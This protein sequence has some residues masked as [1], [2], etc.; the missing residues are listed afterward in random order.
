MNELIY[1]YLWLTI[2]AV[3]SLL[4]IGYFVLKHFRKKT[5]R[6]VQAK[7]ITKRTL[8][9]RAVKSLLILVYT[10][11]LLY[12]AAITL[13]VALSREFDQPEI[14]DYFLHWFNKV[15][16]RYERWA[17]SY[18]KNQHALSVT[19]SNVAATE[20]PMF[21][22]AFYLLTAEEI[23]NHIEQRKDALTTETRERIL[24]GAEQAAK[25][26][27]DPATAN[28]V[29][30]YW[31]NDYLT[32]EN[33][34]YLMLMIM[35]LSSYQKVTGKNTYREILAQQTNSLADELLAAPHHLL[36]DYPG[37]CWP[38]DVVW[39]V[40]AIRRADKILGTDHSLLA[41][42]LMFV[43]D[44]NAFS[45]NGLPLFKTDSRNLACCELPRGS[46]NSG[47]LTFAPELDVDIARKW[48]NNYEK[49]FLMNNDFVVGFREFPF[50]NIDSYSDVD[51]GPVIFGFG[52][53]ASLFGIGAAKRMGRYDRAIP[54]TKELIVLSWPTPFGH[55]LPTVCSWLG[56]RSS[57][58][59]EI[60]ILFSITRTNLSGQ[61]IS[62]SG[63]TPGIIWIA[64]AF[65][66]FF[67]FYHLQKEFFIWK[68][69]LKSKSIR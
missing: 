14:S 66:S 47:I 3:E 16:K 20:W 50:N 32:K 19:Q 26:I 23:Q 52:S 37:E 69:I 67:G 58:L 27:V 31:G 34:F 64:F 25:I 15:S 49:H 45:E 38:N 68:K 22:S 55:L 65:Y 48:Y 21:G 29:K 33:V 51:S 24:I 6:N 57:S 8:I 28:W 42:K 12:P 10:V 61:S 43:L 41:K 63:K 44:N 18:L 13:K 53:V 35:G 11:S 36:D 39:S 46:G 9:L 54:M 5:V 56:A 30:I 1:R 59:G 62:D 7:I 17:Q 2:A 60:A 4:L 40:A